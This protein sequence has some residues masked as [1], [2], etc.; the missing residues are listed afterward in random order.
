MPREKEGYRDMLSILM[1]RYPMLLTKKQVCEI[2][3]LSFQTVCKLIAK[4]KL[5]C[6][7]G[8]IPIGSLARYLCG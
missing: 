4:G 6:D 8:K 1:E 3:D 7:A 5:T 2:L